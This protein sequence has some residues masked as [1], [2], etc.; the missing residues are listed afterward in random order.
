M[1]RACVA[2]FDSPP[3]SSSFT[4]QALHHL[5]CSPRRTE[6]LADAAHFGADELSGLLSLLACD[7]ALLSFA[8]AEALRKGACSRALC[9]RLLDSSDE[10]SLR[11][12]KALLKDERH[13]GVVSAAL[14]QRGRLAG[15][16]ASA[17]SHSSRLLHACK[18][19]RCLH[20]SAELETDAQLGAQCLE[21]AA[22]LLSPSESC[23]A[24]LT[25]LRLLEELCTPACSLGVLRSLETAVDLLAPPCTPSAAPSSPFERGDESALRRR[26]LLLALTAAAGALAAGQMLP[27]CPALLASSWATREPDELA[28]C[29]C[30]LL[31]PED[32]ILTRALAAA[33][34]AHPLLAAARHEAAAALCDPARCLALLLRATRCDAGVLLDMLIAED[35]ADALLRLLL[36]G[37]RCAQ[38]D[39]RTWRTHLARHTGEAGAEC[40]RCLRARLQH[41]ERGGVFPYSVTPLLRRLAAVEE[42]L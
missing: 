35:S 19:V 33:A 25:A 23:Y 17:A 12:L 22:R 21:A 7:D 8:A 34:T 27:S 16:L 2:A 41:L 3:R 42:A 10:A 40:L 39:P 1:P 6:L 14:L 11:L 36:A 29:I 15:C 37:L 30:A 38:A 4:I 32:D 9:E 24:R 13:A 20:R 26:A 18:L 28:D 31:E 5:A